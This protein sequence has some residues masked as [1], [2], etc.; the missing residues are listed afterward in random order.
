MPTSG[1][2]HRQ[3]FTLASDIRQQ[4]FYLLH[5][6][7]MPKKTLWASYDRRVSDNTQYEKICLQTRDM[8]KINAVVINILK[9]TGDDLARSQ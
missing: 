2:M 3:D 9:L 5:L 6:R 4:L 8:C 7:K 1:S